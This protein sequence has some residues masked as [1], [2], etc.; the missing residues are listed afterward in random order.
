MCLCVFESA[1][2]ELQLCVLG[3]SPPS[4]AIQ[5]RDQHWVGGPGGADPSVWHV[6]RRIPACGVAKQCAAAWWCA[7]A[8]PAACGGPVDV[9][10]CGRGGC[11]ERRGAWRVLRLRSSW[12]RL[13]ACDENDKSVSP[14][15][16]GQVACVGQVAC[17]RECATGPERAMVRRNAGSLCCWVY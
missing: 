8:S 11:S 6:H 12:A 14:V 1:A 13:G 16:I 9:W 10:A 3:L 4:D 7:A 15:L 17:E 5:E 2:T